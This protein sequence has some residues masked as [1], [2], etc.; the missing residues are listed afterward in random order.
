MDGPF[1]GCFTGRGRG[2]VSSLEDP[3]RKSPKAGR[4][5]PDV[6]IKMVSGRVNVLTAIKPGR[7]SEDAAPQRPQFPD[8]QSG[9]PAVLDVRF[10]VSS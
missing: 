2:G 7:K 9:P 10:D 8:G 4:E 5:N 1:G 3:L 6:R